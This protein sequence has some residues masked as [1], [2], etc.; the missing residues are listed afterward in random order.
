MHPTN[1]EKMTFYVGPWATLK[2]AKSPYRT[3]CIIC[4]ALAHV[5]FLL[6]LKNGL[7]L[8]IKHPIWS[9]EVYTN[10]IATSPVYLFSTTP[11]AHPKVKVGM[12]APP[13]HNVVQP[14]ALTPMNRQSGEDD[15]PL[16]NME[17]PSPTR[18]AEIVE[19][20]KVAI[21]SSTPKTISS[22][23]E[24]IRQPQPEY[25][26]IARR[27]EEQGNVIL[28]VLVNDKGHP[29]QVEIQKSS[30]FLRLDEAARQAALRALFKP[31]IEN[32]QAIAVYAIVPISFHLT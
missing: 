30:G 16:Q 3:L 10:L 14:A 11:A 6:A 26:P 1:E 4:I 9:K 15:A 25:P 21:I 7:M 24:Y 18:A 29:E 28:R 5:A 8:Q 23:V 22:G 32:G 13:T 20:P 19:T 31:H 12:V 17:A 2:T 27:K